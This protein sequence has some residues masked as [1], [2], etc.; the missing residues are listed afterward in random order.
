VL[1]WLCVTPAR[2]VDWLARLLAVTPSQYLCNPQFLEVSNSWDGSRQVTAVGG[3]LPQLPLLKGQPSRLTGVRRL[4][5]QGSHGVTRPGLW[6]DTGQRCGPPTWR[7]AVGRFFWLGPRVQGP[8]C[9]CNQLQR[10]GVRPPLRHDD[11]RGVAACCFVG[12]RLVWC[13]VPDA[14]SASGA[15]PRVPSFPR[16]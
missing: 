4:G 11:T 13:R 1:Q 12:S 3:I 5:Q 2:H 7:A 10:G 8:E 6:R 14:H 15:P 9:G 16:V